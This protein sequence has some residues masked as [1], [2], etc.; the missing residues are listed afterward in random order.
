MQYGRPLG[1]RWLFGESEA[2]TSR[3]RVGEVGAAGKGDPGSGNSEHEDRGHFEGQQGVRMAGTQQC[4][5]GG[6]EVR[7]KVREVKTG[8]RPCRPLA[9]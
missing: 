9:T 8:S 3:W 7:V 2:V 5:G 1:R 4:G 6:T